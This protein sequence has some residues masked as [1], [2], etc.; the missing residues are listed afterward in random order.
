MF[1]NGIKLKLKFSL[2]NVVIL[3][4]MWRI[5]VGNG[6]EALFNKTE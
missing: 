4:R 6:K 3:R 1:N 5:H 2:M